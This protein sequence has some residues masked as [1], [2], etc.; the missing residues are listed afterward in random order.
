MARETPVYS[1]PIRLSAPHLVGITEP[2]MPGLAWLLVERGSRVSGSATQDSDAAAALAKAGARIVLGNDRSHV[3]ADMSAL[4]WNSSTASTGPERERAEEMRLP[5]LQRDEALAMLVDSAPASVTVAGSHS[6]TTAAV[7]LTS[8]LDHRNPSWVLGAPPAGSVAGHHS[9]GD[10]LIADLGPGEDDGPRPEA[11]CFPTVALILNATATPAHHQ[12][13]DDVL[14]ELEALARRSSTVVLPTDDPGAC[15]L[16]DRLAKRSGPRVITFGEAHDADVRVVQVVWDGTAS[17]VTV[18]DADSSWYTVIVAMPGRH[19]ALAA[20]AAFAAGRALGATAADLAAGIST[21]FNGIERSLTVLGRQAGITVVDSLARHPAEIAA[22]LKAARMLTEGNVIA[23]FE[24]SGL[25]RTMS[26]GLEMGAQL[27]AADDVVLLPVHAPQP[28]SNPEADTG[29]AA[30]ARAATLN[31]MAGH[32]HAW[33]TWHATKVGSGVEE[34]IA[35]LAERGDL[36]VMMGSGAVE[37]LGPRLLFHLGSP[38][39][40]IPAD[41]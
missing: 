33:H 25:A 29:T 15:A 6:T 3:R 10:L 31:G 12:D 1:G 18:Q 11:R 26:L 23:V 17:H 32:V 4:V 36:V 21:R 30:I 27:A 37:R 35:S 39:T 2:G 34:L 19:N 14:D 5:V 28:A 13:L 24:P 8:A 38:A 9:G 40:P 41:L 16:A 20:A 22:D 7:M